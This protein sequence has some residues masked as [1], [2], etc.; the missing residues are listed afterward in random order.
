MKLYSIICLISSVI[1]VGADFQYPS[2][3]DWECEYVNIIE[4][5]SIDTKKFNRPVDANVKDAGGDDDGTGPKAHLKLFSNKS[6]RVDPQNLIKAD[7]CIDKY[8]DPKG[9]CVSGQ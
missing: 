1:L 6:R 5:N 9:R 7:T 3:G 4:D 2:F 8:R